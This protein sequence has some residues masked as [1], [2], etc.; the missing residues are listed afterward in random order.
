MM[1][2]LSSHGT[3]AAACMIMF[4]YTLLVMWGSDNMKPGDGLFPGILAA[5][6]LLFFLVAATA[7]AFIWLCEHIEWK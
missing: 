7:K 6:P 2:D 4:I 1:I 5:G 3:A